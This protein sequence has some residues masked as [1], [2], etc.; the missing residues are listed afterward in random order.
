MTTTNALV[1]AEAA[2]GDP[3]T[4]ALAEVGEADRAPG[5]CAEAMSAPRC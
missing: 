2:P 4:D 3:A 5:G 1:A